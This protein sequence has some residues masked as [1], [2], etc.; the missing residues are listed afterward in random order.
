MEPSPRNGI[1]HGGGGPRPWLRRA[2]AA[3]P[4]SAARILAVVSGK[5]GTGKSF[6]ASNLAVAWHRRGKRVALVDCDFG[7]GNA[8]LLLGCNPRC[9]MQH[10]LTGAA[11]M[12]DVLQPTRFGPGLVAGG[13]GVSSLA[14]LDDR[15]VRALVQGLTWLAQRHDLLILD[16]GPGLSPQSLLTAL[17]AD[18]AL[19]VTN[20]EIAALTDAYALVKC[21]ARHPRPPAL[22]VVVNRTAHREQGRRTFARFAEVA[23]RFV[24]ASIHYAGDV[25][26]DRAV[27]QLRLGQAPLV[28]SS[29]R[30][31][32][33]ESLMAVLQALE[34]PLAQQTPEDPAARIAGRVP[35][36][37]A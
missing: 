19:L 23:R 22:H 9:T 10:L 6:L 24:G 27:I 30:C 37:Q 20:P 21:L 34:G 35:G 14:V 33:A 16:G 25:P 26:E 29:P 18:V 36:L 3:A 5:G 7:L 12:E 31:A 2:A 17:A 11:P 1:E 28:V 13:S 15:H 4:S 32:V 8:H